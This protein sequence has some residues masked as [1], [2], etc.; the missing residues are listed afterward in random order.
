[1][2]LKGGY[3]E[4][5]TVNTGV[6][7]QSALGIGENGTTN[8]I[9]INFAGAGSSFWQTGGNDVWLGFNLT[10]AA[11]QPY[12]FNGFGISGGSLTISA[13]S[14]L[15]ET[16]EVGIE[17]Y[18]NATLNMGTTQTG[19]LSSLQLQNGTGYIGVY[20]GTMNLFGSISA[21]SPATFVIGD[22]AGDKAQG[23]EEIVA[24]ASGST[25][26]T[27]SYGGNSSTGNQLV[28][29]LYVPVWANGGTFSASGGGTLSTRYNQGGSTGSILTIYGSTQDTQNDSVYASQDANSN[30]GTV[31]LTGNITLNANS[32]TD[33]GKNGWLQTEDNTDITV[34]G[35]LTVAIGGTIYPYYGTG[36]GGKFQFGI[37]NVTGNLDMAGTYDAAVGIVNDVAMGVLLQVS[38]TETWYTQW[39]FIQPFEVGSTQKAQWT[40]TTASTIAVQTGTIKHT[41]GW[42]YQ[43]YYG[44]TVTVNNY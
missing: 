20:G 42:N 10:S 25:R 2:V 26:G 1:M 8:T 31:M 39:S 15:I 32:N 7:V 28:D 36:Q 34:K 4:E 38:G 41:S 19:A 23:S 16:S 43:I 29:Y 11:A 37:L 9:D 35:N 3:T 22:G 24:A 18:S 33:I 40:I 21:G 44:N 12:Q 5:Q 17:V 30:A 27:V 13:N 14:G 6:S